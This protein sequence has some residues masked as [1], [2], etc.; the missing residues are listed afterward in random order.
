MVQC[1]LQHHSHAACPL[2]KALSYTWGKPYPTKDILIDG[3]RFSV[4]EILWHFFRTVAGDVNEFFW[5][6][7]ICVDQ[8]NIKERNHQVEF[9]GDIYHQASEAVIWLGAAEKGSAD[10][11]DFILAV[12]TRNLEKSR[13]QSC[14]VDINFCSPFI[15]PSTVCRTFDLAS[16][17]VIA[18]RLLFRKAYW[19]RVW[20]IQEI[21]LARRL[22]LKYGDR[23]IRWEDLQEFKVWCKE[24]GN[25][26]LGHC[27]ES[28][29]C[30]IPPTVKTVINNKLQW[31][32][33]ET[34]KAPSHDL[35]YVLSTYTKSK[36]ENVRDK[37]YGLQG[38]VFFGARVPVDYDKKLHDLTRDIL[39]V[40]VK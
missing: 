21:M 17:P 7:Q 10:V 20:I 11:M 8:Q 1:I 18:L 23:I 36:C 25:L 5:I 38:L 33:G 39:S 15:A 6:D 24:N 3:A 2:Y 31:G 22:L 35:R 40:L 4:R 16:V 26:R 34:W 12:Q 30:L 29:S 28:P 13:D 14:N 32:L 27:Q 37:V 9:M 19:S